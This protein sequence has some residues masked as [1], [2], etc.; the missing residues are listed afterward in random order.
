MTGGAD[1][2]LQFPPTHKHDLAALVKWQPLL[3]ILANGGNAN[4][5]GS[6]ALGQP[7]K[8]EVV[9]RFARLGARIDLKYAPRASP[10]I[11]PDAAG[12]P[13]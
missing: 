2:G 12:Q 8:I 13:R 6:L 7:E 4:V 10:S 5:D 9:H 11:Q 1:E 3:E